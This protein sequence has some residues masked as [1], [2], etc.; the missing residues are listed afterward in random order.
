MFFFKK[1]LYVYIHSTPYFKKNMRYLKMYKQET[2]NKFFHNAKKTKG[3][4]V[5]WKQR[6]AVLPEICA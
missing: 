3:R 1:I 5:K 2:V 4:K 6:Q